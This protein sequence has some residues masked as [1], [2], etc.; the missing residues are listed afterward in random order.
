MGKVSF[1]KQTESAYFYSAKSSTECINNLQC[2]GV[3]CTFSTRLHKTSMPPVRLVVV[4][5]K[6]IFYID[7]R[8]YCIISFLLLA[9]RLLFDEYYLLVNVN[10]Y[11]PWSCVSRFSLRVHAT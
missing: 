10:A 4:Q 9:H 7:V 6:M 2:I 3:Y 1:Q 11:C 5:H 8:V